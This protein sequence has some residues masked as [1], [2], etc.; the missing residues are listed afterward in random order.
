MAESEASPQM[1]IDTGKWL[2]SEQER[3]QLRLA[4]AR[5]VEEKNQLLEYIK[6]GRDAMKSAFGNLVAWDAKVKHLFDKSP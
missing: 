6:F 1:V 4:N 2:Q 5:L 3:Q